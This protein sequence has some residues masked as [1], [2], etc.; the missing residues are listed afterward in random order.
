MMLVAENPIR[1]APPAVEQ[2]AVETAVLRAVARHTMPE[3]A[4]M[5]HVL[6]VGELVDHEVTYHR[7]ALKE[8]AAVE[9]DRAAGRAASPARALPADEHA[10][11]AQAE[12]PR[13]LSEKRCQHL[14]RTVRQPAAQRLAHRLAFAGIAR[15]R[16]Q[17]RDRRGDARPPRA[18]GEVNAPDL[19]ARRQIDLRRRKRQ[20]RTRPAACLL[21]LALDPWPMPLEEALH[22]AGRG[23][24]RHHHLHPAG[25]EDPNCQASCALALADAP[26]FG[27]VLVGP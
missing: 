14:A 6:G 22:R 3:P 27:G 24:G 5:V 16:E 13:V 8:Q 2:L 19:L 9:A 20:G 12:L 23:P 26:P 17:P 10:L 18:A 1:N 7:R 15:E 25:M 11:I 21:A 4:G